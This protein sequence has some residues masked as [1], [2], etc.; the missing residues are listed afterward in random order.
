MGDRSSP[1]GTRGAYR[2][3]QEAAS[4][5]PAGPGAWMPGLDTRALALV[6][7]LYRLAPAAARSGRSGRRAHHPLRPTRSLCCVRG[8]TVV[9]RG[10]DTRV[11][12]FGHPEGDRPEAREWWPRTCLV[13]TE[14]GL[15]RYA[16]LTAVATSRRDCC[17]SAPAVPSTNVATRTGWTTEHLRHIPS[18]RGRPPAGAGPGLRSRRPPSTRAEAFMAGG[19][20]ERDADELDSIAWSLLAAVL[21]T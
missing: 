18:R 21:L 9:A 4:R 15:G 7:F 3:G 1:G 5:H 2:W 8:L 17:S 20:N 19:P 11:A 14:F 12:V 10:H 6:D 13:F 16:P